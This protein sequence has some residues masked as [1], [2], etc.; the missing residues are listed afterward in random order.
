MKLN[1][2]S[3]Q[4]IRD[5][6]VSIPK[7]GLF[8]LIFLLIMTGE[9]FSQTHQINGVVRDAADNSTIV[10]VTIRVKNTMIG[11]TTDIDGKYILRANS[12]K[13]TLVV[14]F[15]GY[16][17][18]HIPIQGKSEINVVLAS[19]VRVLDDVVVTALGIK[20]EKKSLGYSVSEVSG[21]ELQTARDANVVNQLAGKVAGLDVSASSGGSASSSKIILRGNNSLTG[22]NQALIVVDGVPIDNSLVSNAG[23]KWG[24]KDFGSGV[25][26]I[27]PDDIESISVLKGASA[28]ALYGSRAANGVILI[29][30]KKGAA[31][32]GGSKIQVGFSSNTSFEIPYILW[33]LQNEYGAGRNGKFEGPWQLDANGVPKYDPSNASAYGSWGPKM[34]DQKIIDWDGKERTF[35]PQPNNYKD[36]F[37]TGVMANNALSLGGAYKSN[38]FRLTL[39][40]LR[41]GDIVPNSSMSRTN[42]GLNYGAKLHK[43][44]AL[45][46]YGSYVNQ[47]FRNR[48]GLSD[49]HNN[50]NR[51]YIMMPRNIS[52]ESM[53]DYIMDANGKAQTWYMNW[54]WMSNPYWDHQ[55]EQNFDDKNRF[56]GNASLVFELDSN[57]T[58]VLR[59]APDFSTHYLETRDA[60]NGLI[61][62]LGGFSTKRIERQLYNSDFLLSYKK[63]I[64]SFNFMANFGGN[65]MY[66]KSFISRAETQGG[67][68][69]GN[70]YSVENSLNTPKFREELYE[71]AINSLYFSGQVGYKGFLYLDITARNDW[72]STLPKGNNSY[73]YPS[74][75]TGFVFSEL[76]NMSPKWQQIF[77]LGKLRASW[78][79]VGNDAS[80]YQISQTYF[81]DTVDV[82]GP[83]AHVNTTLPPLDLKPERLTSKEVGAELRFWVDRIALDF[84]Y[85]HT[86]AYNQIVRIDISPSSGYRWALIN[87]GN[88]ENKG[89]EIQLST[90]PIVKK[91]FQWSSIINYTKNNSMVIDLAPGV[92]NL[93][94]MEHWGLSI[95]ARPGNP[96][97]DIVGY[98]IQRD[99]NGNK[100]V[101][102]NGMYVRT[103]NTQVLGNINPDF[104]MSFI[105]SFSWKNFS[106][107]M[108]VDMRFGGQMYAGSNMY[109]YGYS[110]NFAETLEGRAD[111]YDSEAARESANV[112]PE[113]WTA[114]GG[115]LAE[116]VYTNGTVLINGNANPSSIQNHNGYYIENGNVYDGS[117]NIVG[118]DLSGKS[119]QRFVNPQL[120]WGQFSNWTNEIHEAFVYDAD[121]VKLREITL[122][123]QL[124]KKYSNKIK[125]KQASVAVYAR[126]LWLIHS[127]VPNVDPEA[128]HDSGN[129][130]GYELYSY[131]YRRTIGFQLKFDF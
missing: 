56:F 116:G 33:N 79:A 118:V 108:L 90:K 127:N 27:N 10:G 12:N 59:S 64:P 53:K 54:P 38:T 36:Y 63:D 86:N 72:S 47:R 66:D 41:T 29:T 39:A 131:P 50:V 93:Q 82:Y 58:L 52:N 62:S 98:A 43:K 13:D 40:D 96:Y 42:I 74:V 95:E 99:A 107:S 23:D 18:Q 80:P 15:V 24:G 48:V 35:S 60:Y 122:G 49:A 109:G 67:L 30:T 19:E 14:S 28:S 126:N 5:L 69:N 31:G 105:N 3:V 46:M 34:E 128:F 73:F 11:T 100:L 16:K 9:I 45:S 77:S 88:I 4:I 115:Y 101:D 1:R 97:G 89:V 76:L 120:Y 84:S 68:K 75:S 123:Y 22:N 32:K 114:S 112:A 8:F 55:Y 117:G 119:N 61:S 70:N 92:D 129:G 113:N 20:R 94:L 106:F 7:F 81:I 103:V 121:Y 111:W 26:D 87:A 57:F 83:I 78:A 130:L 124:P 110:G 71:K 104:K 44:V 17:T 37:R 6:C 2:Y 85:Y 21:E 25:S 65:A 91:D 102:A 51:N 125:A